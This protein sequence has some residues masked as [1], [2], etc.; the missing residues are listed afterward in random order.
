MDTKLSSMETKE[1]LVHAIGC[2]ILGG[3]FALGNL[4][5]RK[6]TGDKLI[7]DT[8]ILESADNAM[9]V[10]LYE[11]Q[12]Q[13]TDKIGFIRLVGAIDRVVERECIIEK[14]MSS[15]DPNARIDSKRDYTIIKV[16]YFDRIK[17][18]FRESHPDD[19]K[20]IEDY[21][22]L[23]VVICTRVFKHLERIWI[24]TEKSKQNAE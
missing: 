23:C 11:L 21:E 16:N 17:T 13:T 3:V 4:F 19:P 22:S 7:V 1:V 10:L 2:F 18:H 20:L 8:K 15:I 9:F 12:C 6:K 5:A 14:N 24:L